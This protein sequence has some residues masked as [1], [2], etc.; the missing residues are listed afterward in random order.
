MRGK[1]L[2]PSI[3]QKEKD[4]TEH[5]IFHLKNIKN[6]NNEE[7]IEIVKLSEMRHTFT[8][9]IENNNDENSI[10]PLSAINGKVD[11]T[12]KIEEDK[13]N[14]NNPEKESLKVQVAAP[15][16]GIYKA[17]DSENIDT[18]ET[19]STSDEHYSTPAM[20]NNNE[21]FIKQNNIKLRFEPQFK[22]K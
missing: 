3:D 15:P 16:S 20:I 12:I 8:N 7:S 17:D 11:E 10:N 18:Y 1:N 21:S 2:L 6:K 19:Y 5:N 14:I 9:D 4:N 13:I 22:L